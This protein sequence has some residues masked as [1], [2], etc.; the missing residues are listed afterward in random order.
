M[1]KI[2]KKLC[3]IIMSFLVVFTSSFSTVM[4]SGN[5]AKMDVDS[6]RKAITSKRIYRL[7]GE[8][9][10]YDKETGAEINP[11]NGT[12]VNL[13]DFQ[14]L[15]GEAYYIKK[16][17]KG[18]KTKYKEFKPSDYKNLT[19][20]ATITSTKKTT[21]KKGWTVSI[22]IKIQAK[23]KSNLSKTYSINISYD[24]SEQ[25]YYLSGSITKTKVKAAGTKQKALL[26]IG[27]TPKNQFGIVESSK[28]ASLSAGMFS[29]SAYTKGTITL[30]AGV[31]GGAG[32]TVG[33]NKTKE[34]FCIPIK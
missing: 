27:F 21:N 19:Y 33:K 12:I 25:A 9:T 6:L 18:D 30:S 10:L 2:L 14:K 15:P 4:A 34:A 24:K 32:V 29:I 28:S 1:N 23:N 7:V 13:K 8:P 3:A 31:K 5:R 16:T 11:T 17:K 26:A 20:K 22:G